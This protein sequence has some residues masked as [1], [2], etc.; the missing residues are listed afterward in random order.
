MIENEIYKYSILFVEDEVAL[1]ENYVIYLK[2]MFENV[3]EASDG[4]EAYRIYKDKKP[5]IMIIDINIPKLNGLDLL[6][7]IRE[8]DPV[9]KAIVLTAH[10]DK[11]FL[12]QATSLKLTSYL[13]K[14]I[15]RQKLNE[16]LDKVR[17]E[18]KNFTTTTIKNQFLGNGYMWNYTSEKLLCNGQVI[19]LTNKEK[20]MFVM[21]MNNLNNV[22]S[23]EQ[24]IQTVWN[25]YIEANVGALRTLLKSL[26]TKLPKGL[27]KNIHGVGYKIQINTP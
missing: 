12:L 9:V 11:N 23:P 8:S 4:E 18:L 13:V 7:K 17:E 22:L 16:A 1:R 2:M 5:D 14:P 6:T 24:I 20:R 21:F 27:I 15:S 26:R 19:D 10:T 25:S 3:Y